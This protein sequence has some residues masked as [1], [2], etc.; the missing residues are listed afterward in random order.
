LALIGLASFSLCRNPL[1]LIGR[2]VEPK[3]LTE[4]GD[5]S[6]LVY[7]WRFS[8]A[9]PW[10]LAIDNG[11]THAEPGEAPNPNLVLEASWADFVATGKPDANR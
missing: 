10:H 8:D 11:S 2:P 6:R 3:R 1:K 5:G 4:G 9:D 7:P